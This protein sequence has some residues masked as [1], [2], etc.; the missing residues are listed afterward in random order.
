VR[1]ACRRV[2]E[3]ETE[4]ES[5]VSHSKACS[6]SPDCGCYCPAAVSGRGYFERLDNCGFREFNL[7]KWIAYG[8]RDV[9]AHAEWCFQYLQEQAK[10]V[11][12][13]IISHKHNDSHYVHTGHELRDHEGEESDSD[14]EPDCSFEV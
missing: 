14:S 2:R 8:S 10:L 1:E 7:G 5:Y 4:Y 9:P 3:E 6:E 13:A 12:Q 11:K